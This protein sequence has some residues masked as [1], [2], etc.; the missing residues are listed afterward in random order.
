MPPFSHADLIDSIDYNPIT[1]VAVWRTT[2]G[3]RIKDRQ[4]GYIDCDGYWSFG[5]RGGKYKLHRAIWF[6]MTGSWE[7]GLIDHR[8][9]DPTNNK[10][11]NLRLATF[12]QNNANRRQSSSTGY[13]GVFRIKD[14]YRASI[15]FN[16]VVY[17]LGHYDSA[18]EASSVY[19]AKAIELFGE[20]ARW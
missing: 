8:D 17:N 14:K 16:N 18:E 15:G 9:T 4:V 3:R 20:F 2:I 12:Q 5:F 10:W 7:N 6:Y 19:K 1:G 11:V 13:K